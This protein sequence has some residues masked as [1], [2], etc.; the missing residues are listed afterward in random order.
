V[1]DS[2]NAAESLPPRFYDPETIELFYT[3]SKSA[4]DEIKGVIPKFRTNTT[5]VLAITT[6]AAAFFGFDD[7]AKHPIF[8]LLALAAYA[9]A[10]IVAA[11][12]YLPKNV[13]YNVAGKS[14]DYVYTHN[15]DRVPSKGDLQ[16]DYARQWQEGITKTESQVQFVASL[17][18]TL[19]L[20]V[21]SAVVFAG[22]AV[23]LGAEP[24]ESPT[25]PI[26]VIIRES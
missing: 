20:L 12:I 7:A 15:P 1:T 5:V 2:S 22:L 24:A 9:V 14:E 8:G 23:T 16:L 10:A 17:F 3:E 4:V 19:V 21:V 13:V 11:V 25:E 18:V 26:E 6:G